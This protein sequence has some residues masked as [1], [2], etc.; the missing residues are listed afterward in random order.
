MVH[1]IIGGH[2]TGNFPA[3][4][5]FYDRHGYL[6]VDVD[7]WEFY[8]LEVAEGSRAAQRIDRWWKFILIYYILRTYGASLIKDGTCVIVIYRR[9]VKLL[10]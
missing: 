10:E 9:R 1:G 5:V 2:S 3:S 8:W 6:R 7:V 4:S